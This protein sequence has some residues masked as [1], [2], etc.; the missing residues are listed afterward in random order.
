MH[1]NGATK[2]FGDIREK[3]LRERERRA[4]VEER[5]T[6]PADPQSEHDESS[7]SGG[8]RHVAVRFFDK[9]E[10]PRTG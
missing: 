2:E 6:A 7:D 4:P 5:L 9:S 10:G 3:T 1:S 8:A